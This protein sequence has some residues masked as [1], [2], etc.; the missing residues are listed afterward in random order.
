MTTALVLPESKHL[1]ARRPSAFGVRRRGSRQA[2]AAVL[3]ALA[4]LIGLQIGTAVVLNLWFPGIIDPKFG[5][6]LASVQEGR[7]ADPADT[8]TVVMVGSLRTYYGLHSGLLSA[9]LTEELHNPVSVVNAGYFGGGPLTE[10]LFWQRLCREGFR[11][12][13]LLIEVMPAYLNDWAPTAEM[14]EDRLPTNHIGWFDLP[15]LERY[16][17]AT[18]PTLRRDMAL[19]DATIWYDRR[20][21][22]LHTVA[23]GL[24]PSP[25]TEAIKDEA[26]GPGYFPDDPKPELR[27]WAL[28]YTRREYQDLAHFSFTGRDRSTNILRELLASCRRAGVPTCLVLMPE[29]PQ[30]RSWYAPGAWAK[31]QE[32]MEQFCREEGTKLVVA[33]EW[34]DKEDFLDSHHMLPRGAEEFQRTAGSRSHPSPL[35]SSGENSL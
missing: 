8:R 16:R 5:S 20:A 3:S 15:L 11:P 2:C 7:A 30:F 1:A 31:F 18:R 9:A 26:V 35:A 33:R 27:Q 17:G 25:Q 10:L 32:S 22:F 34:I 12:D 28:N 13:L 14:Q 6:R 24:L 23:P 29:G 4:M 21:N 19:M